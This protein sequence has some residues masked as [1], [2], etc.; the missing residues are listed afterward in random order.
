M[1]GLLLDPVRTKVPISAEA[2]GL[3]RDFCYRVGREAILVN[4]QAIGAPLRRRV[5][6]YPD[7]RPRDTLLHDLERGWRKAQPQQFRLD[8]RSARQGTNFFISERAVTIVDAFR[9]AHWNDDDY[10]VSVMETWVKVD[11]D[12]AS[13]GVRSCMW[14]GS[15]AL[16]RWYQRSG[17][18]SDERLLRDIDIGATIDTHD[19]GA[20]PDLDDVRVPVNAAGEG[21]RGAM[22]LPPEGEGEN[23]VFHARTFF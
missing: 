12:R 19:R 15:H 2:R 17:A 13:A 1:S 21:W 3:A 18:R 22:M 5:A 11:R 8:F 10:G 4:E 14:V 9:L 23:L 20:F 7:R 16:A 6:R